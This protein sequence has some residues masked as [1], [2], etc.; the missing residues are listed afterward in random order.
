MSAILP[1]LLIF[2]LGSCASLIVHRCVLN[3]CI[4][5][6]AGAGIATVLWIGGVYILLWLVAP[7]ELGPPL[8]TP[9][10]LTF[11]TASAAAAVAMCLATRKQR[12]NNLAHRSDTGRDQNSN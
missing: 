1:I 12:L 10:L 11:L 4:C 3:R 6:L 8:L 5:V 9:V 2:I 7:N